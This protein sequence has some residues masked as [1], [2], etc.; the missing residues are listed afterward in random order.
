M[1]ENL[2]KCV[3]F[4]LSHG[5]RKVEDEAATSIGSR[6][7]RRSAVW[8]TSLD[9]LRRSLARTSEKWKLILAAERIT[10]FKVKVVGTVWQAEG[11]KGAIEV[12]F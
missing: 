7:K 6:A 8:T 12:G 3:K 5:T 10:G 11:K 1:G 4:W 9:G 2:H